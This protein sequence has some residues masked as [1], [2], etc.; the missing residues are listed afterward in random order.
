MQFICYKKARRSDRPPLCF[1]EYRKNQQTQKINAPYRVHFIF[2]KRAEPYQN[3][4]N[5]SK[6]TSSYEFR[7]QLLLLF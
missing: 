4:G 3:E 7:Q 1:N 6:R 2:V 5:E